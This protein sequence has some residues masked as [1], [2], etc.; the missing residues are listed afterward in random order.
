MIL[1]CRGLNIQRDALK[2]DKRTLRNDKNSKR[3]HVNEL[4]IFDMEEN[5]KWLL[6]SRFPRK[7]LLNIQYI[8]RTIDKRD[9]NERRWYFGRSL[10]TN[11]LVIPIMPAY[12]ARIYA[13]Y[14]RCSIVPLFFR[15]CLPIIIPSVLY[16]QVNNIFLSSLR[17]NAWMQALKFN[18]HVIW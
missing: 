6:E 14:T 18:F 1:F 13:I 4:S 10:I 5:W 9:D 16:T 3:S 11:R 12:M 15:I 2:R 17:I 8:Q 7:L